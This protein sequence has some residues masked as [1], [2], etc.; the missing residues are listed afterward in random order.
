MEIKDY[1][2]LL[3]QWL[4]YYG[5]TPVT[6]NVDFETD[7]IYTR[8]RFEVSKFGNVDA[9]CVVKYVP[10]GADALYMQN[11]SEWAFKLA[12]NHRTGPPVGLASML[13]VYPL[14]IVEGIT[15]ALGNFM[16]SYCPK[17]FAAAEFPCILDVK[18]G[19]L[20]RYEKTPLWGYA[21]YG[22]YR[23]ETYQFFSPESWHKAGAK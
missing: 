8:S 10:Q 5:F 11:F 15:P 9:Y 14:L 20:Y 21:Y 19:S 2:T 12:Y 17:H 13:V 23:N 7:G 22:T 1:L 3:P 18:T 16:E 6:V 4:K